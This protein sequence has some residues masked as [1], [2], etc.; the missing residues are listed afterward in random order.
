MRTNSARS[1]RLFA[2]VLTILLSL[3]M[4]APASATPPD[5]ESVV[6]EVA[7]I[8][9]AASAACGFP[10]EMSVALTI[11]YSR[12]VLQNGTVIEI[13]RLTDGTMGFTNLVTGASVTSVYAGPFIYQ[14]EPDG[15]FSYAHNGIYNI[16]TLP[17]HGNLIMEIGRIVFDA[18]NNIVFEA[19]KHP[20]FLGGDVQGLC[21]ALG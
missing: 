14:L 11:K 16:I 9:E 6:L 18:D 7:Q 1:Y 5:F 19:G 8:H 13:E 4:V 2:L 17:G 15:A 10:I 3:A 12:H 21:I 20:G